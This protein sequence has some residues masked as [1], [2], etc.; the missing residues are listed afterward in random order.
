ME[1]IT[2]SRGNNKVPDIPLWQW[3]RELQSPLN[4]IMLHNSFFIILS[5]YSRKSVHLSWGHSKRQVAGPAF[6]LIELKWLKR[7]PHN[8][9]LFTL[10][11]VKVGKTGVLNLFLVGLIRISHKSPVL[12]HNWTIIGEELEATTVANQQWWTFL[13]PDFSY[14]MSCNHFDREHNRAWYIYYMY[15]LWRSLLAPRSSHSFY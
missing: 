14:N 3:R 5:H 6:S 13:S 1:A 8:S 15:L 7:Y 10:A 4:E 12:I 2:L 9:G 11:T